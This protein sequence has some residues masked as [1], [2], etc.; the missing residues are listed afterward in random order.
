MNECEHNPTISDKI[1]GKFNKARRSIKSRYYLLYSAY[2]DLVSE[3]IPSRSVPDYIVQRVHKALVIEFLKLRGIYP[4]GICFI[5]GSSGFYNEAI[6]HKIRFESY[7][8]QEIVFEIEY[9][10][11]S[12][13]FVD[14][15]LILPDRMSIIKR[16]NPVLIGYMQKC[17]RQ[18]R[19]FVPIV[20]T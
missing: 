12:A 14:S 6:V 11:D 17:D 19:Y 15:N 10:G 3:I 7:H 2:L 8:P 16:S 4:G 1:C 20:Y 9:T 13:N 5:Q 18:V